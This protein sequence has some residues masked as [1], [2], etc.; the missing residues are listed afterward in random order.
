MIRSQHLRGPAALLLVFPLVVLAG[1]GYGSHAPVR[2]SVTLDGTPV[3]GGAIVFIPQGD[4][5]QSGQG[6][7][8]GEIVGGKYALEGAKAPPPG[9]YLVQIIWNKKTGRQVPSN[10]PPNTIDETVQVIPAAYNAN[11]TLTREIKAGQN[12]YDFEL[13]SR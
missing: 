2:G 10:D 12:T 7:A 8:G 3:D 5:G 6:N 9:K 4:S 13:K 1:C 11:S